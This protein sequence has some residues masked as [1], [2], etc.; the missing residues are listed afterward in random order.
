MWMDTFYEDFRVALAPAAGSITGP[1]CTQKN[2]LK[3]ERAA[4]ADSSMSAANIY[5]AR[6]CMCASTNKRRENDV[7]AGMAAS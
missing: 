4:T 5:N 7:L 1:N 6:V 2:E 3:C